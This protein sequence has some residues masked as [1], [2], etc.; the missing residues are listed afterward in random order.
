MPS[1]A[2]TLSRRSVASRWRYLSIRSLRERPRLRENREPSS[3]ACRGFRSAFFIKTIV[4]SIEVPKNCI[5]GSCLA[6][7]VRI[8]LPMPEQNA[9][10]L[11]SSL[12][13][14]ITMRRVAS[15]RYFLNYPDA[16]EPRAV[17]ELPDILPVQR[18]NLMGVNELLSS[19]RSCSTGYNWK[20]PVTAH[21][22]EVFRFQYTF[23]P[24]F[25][26]I[27]QCGKRSDRSHS[28]A[29]RLCCG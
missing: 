18:P 23:L 11:R 1:R 27:W 9:W 3:S 26:I 21:F 20:P 15:G 17:E 25:L 19:A 10:P 6:C 28:S 13:H 29:T 8:T 24:F 2:Y 5:S 16:L 14:L 12:P 7:H 22:R 4:G